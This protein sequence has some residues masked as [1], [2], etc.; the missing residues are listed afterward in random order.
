MRTIITL[1]SDELKEAVCR[2]LDDVLFEDGIDRK[3]DRAS[4]TVR[5]LLDMTTGE[6]I[7]EV[8]GAR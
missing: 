3:V 6:Y 4:G 8:E 2:Y 7:A 1:S 5:I